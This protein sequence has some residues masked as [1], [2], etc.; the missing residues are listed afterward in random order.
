MK[1]NGWMRLGIALSAAWLMVIGY[2]AYE[3]WA[4]FS[5]T[6]KYEVEQVGFLQ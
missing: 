5:K 1:L 4:A 2:L 3:E 6:K